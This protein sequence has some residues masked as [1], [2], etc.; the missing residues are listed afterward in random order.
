MNSE[1]CSHPTPPLD[2]SRRRRPSAL[3]V[4][5]SIVFSWLLVSSV[6]A[7]AAAAQD[8]PD[9]SGHWEMD[10]ELSE[11][12]A[13]KLRELVGE[14]PGDAGGLRGGG[15]FGGRGGGFRSGRGNLDGGPGR[16]GGPDRPSR[17]E[18]E[19]R[20]EEMKEGFERLVIAQSDAGVRITFADG[21]EQTLTADNKKRRH[22]TPRGE[23]VV[24]ARW[25][26]AGLIV[27][28]RGERRSTTETYY[29]TADGSLL[30]VLVD[31]ETPGPVGIVSFK[32]I[33]RPFDPETSSAEPAVRD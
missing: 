6:G 3:R 16:R 7:L 21:R 1:T 24:R 4:S 14:A 33:Y 27:S 11:D 23:T 19:R 17:E 31:V 30:T 26:D 2:S 15:G 5:G 9:L 10:K 8:P 25:K 20:M 18:I 13:E 22:E 12:P 28:S 32:R 29:V